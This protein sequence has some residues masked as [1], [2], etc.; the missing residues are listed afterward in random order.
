MSVIDE[1]RTIQKNLDEILMMMSN[2]MNKDK[3]EKVFV[4]DD[5]ER[6]KKTI[7]TAKMY[8][9]TLSKNEAEIFILGKVIGNYDAVIKLL[10]RAR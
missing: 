4:A 6:L 2:I 1:L 9:E 8:A 5:L 7:F 3:V 10:E